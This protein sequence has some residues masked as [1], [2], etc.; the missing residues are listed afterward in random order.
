M[1]I[2]LAL[3]V[4][5]VIDERRGSVRLDSALATLEAEATDLWPS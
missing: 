3:A 2:V 4:P 1:V 5:I